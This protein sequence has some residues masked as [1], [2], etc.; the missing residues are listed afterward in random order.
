MKVSAD[1]LLEPISAEKPCGDDISY[2][3]AFQEL[4]KLM[5]G[6]PETQFSPAEPPNWR[7]IEEQSTALFGRSKNLRVTVILIAALVRTQQ[8]VGFCDGVAVLK[9]LV[10]KYWQDLYPRLD[11]EDNNDPTERNN[12]I[13]NLVA[14]LRTMGDSFKILEGLRSV[15]LCE[16]RQH[17]RFCWDDIANS[18]ANVASTAQKR[19]PAASDIEAA[20]RDTDP[21]AIQAAAAAV[22]EALTLAKGLQ[23][24]LDD[25]VGAG[26]GAD[27]TPLLVTL[28]EI[29]KQFTA[30]L[31]VASDAGETPVEQPADAGQPAAAPREASVRTGLS[32]SVESRQQVLQALDL[33]CSYYSKHEPSSPVPLLV[34]RVRRLVELDFLGIIADLTPEALDKMRSVAGIPK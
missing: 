11:P 13:G 27:F 12:I 29:K 33:V 19:V 9:A 6:K 5:L 8:F 34:Q 22:S 1:N 14:P 31:P 21:A 24:T 32:G 30:Y 16:S 10:E 28:G 15:P 2:E 23:K 4:E 18:R 25:L 26:R 17:G 20:F 7:E 3:P